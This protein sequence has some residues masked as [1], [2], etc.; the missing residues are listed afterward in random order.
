MTTRSQWREFSTVSSSARSLRIIRNSALTPCFR[1]SAVN[2]RPTATA[3]CSSAARSRAMTLSIATLPHAKESDGCSAG[4][5]DMPWTGQVRPTT[6]GELDS[7]FTDLRA[8]GAVIEKDR[9][10]FPVRQH[11]PLYDFDLLGRRQPPSSSRA[12]VGWHL[13]LRVGMGCVRGSPRLGWLVHAGGEAGLIS[14]ELRGATGLG[15]GRVTV[16]PFSSSIRGTQPGDG[17]GP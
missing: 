7:T 16:A 10:G 3:F 15:V 5:L 1:E 4:L 6:V 9:D 13:I 11:D 17:R 8:L 2:K 14:S 12:S